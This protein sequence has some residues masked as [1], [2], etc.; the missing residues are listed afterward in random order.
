MIE[1]EAMGAGLH[2]LDLLK[3]GNRGHVP[4]LREVLSVELKVT[5]CGLP[6]QIPAKSRAHSVELRGNA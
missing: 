3:G 2:N 5:S 4:V 1:V 6:Y